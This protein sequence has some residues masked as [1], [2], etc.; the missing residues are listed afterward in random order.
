LGRLHCHEVY[1]PVHGALA[2]VVRAVDT[3]KRRESQRYHKVTMVDHPFGN[4]RVDVGGEGHG[5]ALK[6]CSHIACLHQLRR[7]LRELRERRMGGKQRG[8]DE[9]ETCA[10]TM[11]CHGNPPEQRPFYAKRRG[12]VQMRFHRRTERSE[13]L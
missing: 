6:N 13:A 11:G 2:R 12:P 7:L 4:G 9:D 10:A 5:S 3:G 8:A 1:D